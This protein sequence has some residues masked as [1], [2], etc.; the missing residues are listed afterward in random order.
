MA[1]I[2]DNK[3]RIFDTILTTEGRRQLAAGSLKFEFAS[4]SDA[5]TFY[6]GDVSSGSTDAGKRIFFEATANGRNQVTLVTSDDGALVPYIGPSS[7][8]I[9]GDKIISGTS[10]V[11]SDDNFASTV[12]G[13]LESSIDNFRNMYL[14]GSK[15]VFSE[16]DRFSLS[17]QSGSFLITDELPIDTRRGVTQASVSS[18]ESFYQDKRLSHIPNFKYL[19][20]VNKGK[21]KP[22]GNYPVPNQ[23]EIT[24]FD[25]LSSELA[26]KEKIDITFPSTSADNN[27][28]IQMF[29]ASSGKVIKLDIIDFGEFTVG[30]NESRTKQVYFVGKIFKDEFGHST[31]VNIFVISFD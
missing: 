4:F 15:D 13:L 27:L 19:P 20:P 17:K 25:E 10:I 14:L 24:T 5:N 22:L 30:E 21:T 12:D 28:V 6:E 11:S 9:V 7:L 16:I 29:E 1:G 23:P 26:N 8:K 31:F 18:I 3:S 2:L